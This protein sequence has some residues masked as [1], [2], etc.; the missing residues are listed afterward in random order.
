MTIGSIFAGRHQLIIR[1]DG[2]VNIPATLNAFH[3]VGWEQLPNESIYKVTIE[4]NGSAQ[5]IHQAIKRLR[6]VQSSESDQMADIVSPQEASL[7]DQRTIGILDDFYIDQRTIGILDEGDD[8]YLSIYSQEYAFQV[9]AVDA[10]PYATGSGVIVA[11]IDTGVDSDHEFLVNNL[12]QGW[13]FVDNDDLP[14]DERSNH[15]SNG[16]GRYDEGWGH[17]SHVAGIIKTI[18]PGVSIMPLRAVDSDGSADL[19]HI[20][21]AMQFAIDNGAK[22]INLSMSIQDPSPALL[23]LIDVARMSNILVVTSAGNHDSSSLTYP[24]TEVETLTVTSVD[25]LNRKSDFA[26]YSQKIDVSAPGESI[27]SC[28]PGNQYVYR[29]GTSMAAP[30][31]A[32]QAAII[33]ELVPDASYQYVKGRIVNHSLDIN[34]SNPGFRNKLGRGLCDVWNSITQQPQ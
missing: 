5:A 23:H 34:N 17:G 8:A 10:W 1:T 22:V 21:Q 4:S 15:D 31:V 26:N 33:F 19:F 12:V 30:I 7:L 16:N 3:V 20:M 28:L 24:A 29:S 32:G 6:V 13:D 11:V 14:E 18:A 9:R 27:L 2:P 25:H